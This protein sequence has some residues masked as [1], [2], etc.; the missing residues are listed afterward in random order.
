METLN[1]NFDK[2]KDVAV[3]ISPKWYNFLWLK[4]MLNNL[5]A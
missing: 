3:N 4:V 5:I 2:G 1:A